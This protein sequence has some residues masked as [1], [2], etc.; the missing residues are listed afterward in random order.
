M[1]LAIEV[2]DKTLEFLKAGFTVEMTYIDG[3]I[4]FAYFT[5][6]YNSVE[7]AIASNK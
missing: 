5:E 6:D 3:K 1:R 7:E 4:D 2:E